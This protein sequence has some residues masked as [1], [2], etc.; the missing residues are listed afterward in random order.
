MDV[1]SLPRVMRSSTRKYGPKTL[2][3][4][5]AGTSCEEY[6]WLDV[7]NGA[8]TV[9]SELIR[10]GLPHEDS[11][12]IAAPFQASSLVAEIGVMLAGGVACPYEPGNHSFAEFLKEADPWAII[13]PG[14]ELSS[15]SNQA[16][17]VKCFELRNIEPGARTMLTCDEVETLVDSSGPSSPVLALSS[18]DEPT[19]LIDFTSQNLCWAGVT[20]ARAI[21]AKEDDSW[22]C[23]C[24]P[25]SPFLRINGIYAALVSGG[26]LVLVKSLSD[27]HMLL[28]FWIGRP[29][30]A[31]MEA[32]QVEKVARAL[33]DEASSLT[34]IARWFVNVAFRLNG[35][36]PGKALQPR[37]WWR[38]ISRLGSSRLQEALGGCLKS[39]LA[40][41]GEV[42]I[43]ATKVMAS[44]SIEVYSFYGPPEACGLV[45]MKRTS[46]SLPSGAVG[47]VL[48]GTTVAISPDSEILVSGSNVMLSHHQIAPGNNPIFWDGRLR[49]GQKGM[50]D[51]EGILF[52]QKS[53]N[54]TGHE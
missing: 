49:T 51:T 20:L 31:V 46:E 14:S 5:H 36:I 21:E 13:A 30:I 41:M 15:L 22:L 26:E 52:L 32:A 29:T 6:T 23:P 11:V 19:Q 34:G 53:P 27:P 12:V 17:D 2:I 43:W 38:E 39:V 24:S 44:A 33:L 54:P 4:E 45:A 28:P 10:A 50:L 25:S 16:N 3:R 47:R 8:V 35:A 1:T 18:L 7:W 9:A 37:P 40:G 48:E 42:G